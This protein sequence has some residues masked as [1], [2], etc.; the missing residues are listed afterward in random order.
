[1]KI[2]TD[3]LSYC[4]SAYHYYSCTFSINYANLTQV[5]RLNTLLWDVRF[6]NTPW[7]RPLMSCYEQW[8]RYM[9]YLK[10]SE[11]CIWQA[12]WLF[13]CRL[14][15]K[16]NNFFFNLFGLFE[17]AWLFLFVF[18]LLNPLQSHCRCETLINPMLRDVSPW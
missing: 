12:D 6:I 4:Y 14:L 9:S 3:V 10:K 8:K 17:W 2:S 16:L 1:M 7:Q 5:S 11:P 15:F 18:N 13:K